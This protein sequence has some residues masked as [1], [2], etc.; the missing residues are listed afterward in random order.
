MGCCCADARN[1]QSIIQNAF[2][3]PLENGYAKYEKV[4]LDHPALFVLPRM[5]LSYCLALQGTDLS[6]E[7]LNGVSFI[8]ATNKAIEYV[9]FDYDI[10]IQND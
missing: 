10:P 2:K 1:E 6:Q 3:N 4:N 9:L 7:D 5:L 8:V